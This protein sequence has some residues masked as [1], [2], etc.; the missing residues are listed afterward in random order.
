MFYYDHAMSRD[1]VYDQ[2]KPAPEKL[3]LVGGLRAMS[4]FKREPGPLS[5]TDISQEV[6]HALASHPGCVIELSDGGF[7]S[8][9][10]IRELEQMMKDESETQSADMSNVLP[11]G[12]VVMVGGTSI[13]DGAGNPGDENKRIAKHMRMEYGKKP[14]MSPSERKQALA[15]GYSKSKRRKR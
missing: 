14:N 8:D 2:P 3:D 7:L 15:I 12:F 10:L 11:S 6:K 1:D 5:P 9:S 13:D 4:M